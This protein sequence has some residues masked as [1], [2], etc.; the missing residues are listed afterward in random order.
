M[1]N[2]KDY[3]VTDTTGKKVADIPG[4]KLT[5]TVAQNKAVFDKLGEAIIDKINDAFDYLYDKGV[6]TVADDL[7]DLDDKVN[8]NKDETDAAIEAVDDKADTNAEGIETVNGRVDSNVAAIALAN[9]RIDNII[10]LPDGSTTADAELIDI[11]V[12]ADGTNYASAGDAVRGQVSDLKEDINKTNG[13]IEEYLL[14]DP[15][16]WNKSPYTV[17]L[18]GSGKWIKET[19]YTVGLAEVGDK[20]T[21]SIQ[22]VTG[23]T[24]PNPIAIYLYNNSHTEI[25][26]VSH[27]AS[28]ELTVLQTDI[29]AGLS[30]IEFMLYP[31]LATAMTSDAV[32]TGVL[33]IKGTIPTIYYAE[34]LKQYVDGR[35]TTQLSG[36]GISDTVSD[37]QKSGLVID[38]GT[39]TNGKYVAWRTGNLDSNANYYYTDYIDIKGVAQIGVVCVFADS[40]GLAFYDKDKTFISGEGKGSASLGDLIIMEVPEGAC[41]LRTSYYPGYGFGLKIIIDDI[42]VS[43]E[44]LA[45]AQNPINP[46][47]YN[48]D[49]ISVFN[50][51][52]CVGDSLTKGTFNYREGGTT[53]HYL[54][55]VKYSYPTILHKITGIETTNKGRGGYTSVQWYNAEASS[56]L[57][58]YDM[59]IIQLGVNDVG[60]YGTWGQDS[61][62]AF[63]NIINKLKTQNNNI[64]IFVA[65]IIPA[66]SYQSSGYL[67][68]S[69]DMLSWLQTTYASDP[70]VIPLDMQQY[71][72]TADDTAYNCGHLSALGYSR[73]AQDYKSYISY[74]ISKH[75]SDFS[76]VQFIGTNY[77]YHA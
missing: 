68:F 34:N 51:I 36:T 47:N 8:D 28:I 3:K 58:G 61:I 76:E 18:T 43:L 59:A 29:D 15:V 46:C 23:A 41:Y 19:I 48:G 30:T 71:G 42:Q 11:R 24:N 1:S 67:A 74:Y 56:D 75:M 22:S 6:D 37:F 14:V 72:H 35:I 13:N 17:P 2:I 62:D 32:Y 38:C 55:D 45:D 53:N 50:K 70:N 20:Y 52:L 60:V 40:A 26:H 7:G 25:R 10:A 57:S 65:N 69:S 66:T 5:G 64:K 21:F 12:G 31:S 54:E 49:E 73:L 77:Q 16:L 39:P 44:R 4:D 27:N 9:N 33:L 63:T